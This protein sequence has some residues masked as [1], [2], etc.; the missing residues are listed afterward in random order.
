MR[1][2]AEDIEVVDDTLTLKCEVEVL[3]NTSTDPLDGTTKV[4][5]DIVP[6][7]GLTLAEF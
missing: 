4:F 5:L 6:K 7:A 1:V 2:P 3:K